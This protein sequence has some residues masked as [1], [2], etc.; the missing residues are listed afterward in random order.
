ME[1]LRKTPIKEVD[2]STLDENAMYFVI[3]SDGT[4][5][6]W[7]GLEIKLNLSL[8][9]HIYLPVEQVS[10]EDIEEIAFE[11]T[12]SQRDKVFMV[13]GMKAMQ[14]LIFNK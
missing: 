9:T 14:K 7:R 2:L 11:K 3:E 13:V 12:R 5:D 10:E 4:N 8:F 1:L 6:A